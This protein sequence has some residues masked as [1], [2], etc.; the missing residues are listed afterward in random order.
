MVPLVQLLKLF[1]V[2]TFGTVFMKLLHAWNSH[3][4]GFWKFHSTRECLPNASVYTFIWWM[5][6]NSQLLSTTFGVKSSIK[7]PFYYFELLDT[8]L[9]WSLGLIVLFLS[10]L[11]I[12][13][14]SLWFQFNDAMQVQ[15][16]D[17]WEYSCMLERS[18]LN[19]MPRV[20]A[21]FSI[22][23][24]HSPPYLCCLSTIC[25]AAAVTWRC[26]CILHSCSAFKL[27]KGG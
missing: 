15:W 2:E 19:M 10:A 26:R 4:D 17:L 5:I 27:L 22:L 7:V 13:F 6:L 21:F 3:Q 14:C 18:D 24:L 20:I 12:Y 9:K 23:M 8:F 25:F 16:F 11:L 1:A